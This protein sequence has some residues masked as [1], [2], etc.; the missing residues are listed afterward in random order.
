LNGQ[1]SLASS[2]TRGATLSA[3]VRQGSPALQKGQKSSLDGL[4]A[5]NPPKQNEAVSKNLNEKKAE[6]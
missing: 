2:K 3:T 1:L 4:P 5:T 6:P